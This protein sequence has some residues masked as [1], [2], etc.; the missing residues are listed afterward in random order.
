MA[1]FDPDATDEQCTCLKCGTYRPYYPYT[2]ADPCLCCRERAE[3]RKRVEHAQKAPGGS[4]YM[5]A[6]ARVKAGET[7]GRNTM[8]LTE[9]LAKQLAEWCDL[10]D[11]KAMEVA[12]YAI[13]WLDERTYLNLPQVERKDGA[14]AD[15]G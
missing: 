2:D 15:C 9:R 7:R 1:G 13:K 14:D 12:D 6:M 3:Q 11:Q 10:N 4:A 8:T 5:S